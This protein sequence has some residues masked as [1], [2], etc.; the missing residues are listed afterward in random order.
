MGKIYIT[1]HGETQW[2][3]EKRMQGHKNS[4]LTEQ[5]RLQAQWLSDRLYDTNIDLVLSSP[6]ERALTTSEI[7]VCDRDIEILAVEDL[8]E[9]N[10][11]SW[12]GRLV[13]ELEVEY[14]E[15]HGN[16]WN[17]PKRFVPEG[18]ESFQEL[19]ERVARFINHLLA[20]H[21]EKDILVV[22]HGVVI[23]SMLNLL[24]QE[25]D[26]EKFWEGPYI[27]P[28]SLSTVHLD[29]SGFRVEKMAD[30]SHY[31]VHGAHKGWYG[32]KKGH[33]RH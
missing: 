24:H 20:E 28:T 17:N 18:G 29:A 33:H 19:K 2:N 25:G 8:R 5:G 23:K 27:A 30:T 26:L 16:F 11:G 31:K 13:E 6:L 12:E 9:I 3:I 1:R 22:A 15:Q 4:P 32:A 10:L 21:G 7:I 14:P